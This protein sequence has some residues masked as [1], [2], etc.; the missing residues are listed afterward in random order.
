MIN[1]SNLDDSWTRSYWVSCVQFVLFRSLVGDIYNAGRL[2]VN[3]S[4]LFLIG[5]MILTVGSSDCF[6]LL[7]GQVTQRIFLKEFANIIVIAARIGCGWS[8]WCACAGHVSG[9]RPALR[10]LRFERPSPRLLYLDRPWADA[11]L[12]NANFTRKP[13]CLTTN[14]CRFCSSR[15]SRYLKSVDS[16]ELYMVCMLCLIVYHA[17]II[18]IFKL[19]PFVLCS[20]FTIWYL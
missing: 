2:F 5:L 7:F 6:I 13:V 10:L 20:A 1:G 17:N 14:L 8:E 12:G 15:G 19:L 3:E 18:I 4:I 16:V 11:L 9:R